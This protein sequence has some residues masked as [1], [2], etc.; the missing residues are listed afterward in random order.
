M[1]QT[2][3][4]RIV[5][6]LLS[7]GYRNVSPLELAGLSFDFPAAFLG[8]ERSLDLVLVADLA[9]DEPQSLLRR[10]ESVAR[11]LDVMRSKRPITL[12]LAGPK[13]NRDVLDAMSRVCRVLSI[14][15]GRTEDAA[16]AVR[17]SLAVLMPL[18]VARPSAAT[19]EPLHKVRLRAGEIEKDIGALIDLAPRGTRAVEERLHRLLLELLPSQQEIG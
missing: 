6:A 16:S 15:S 1:T 10:V 3:T 2:P 11:A 17:N 12:V 4:D 19:A 14:T 18:K 13:P 7:A 8:D 9:F 5:D